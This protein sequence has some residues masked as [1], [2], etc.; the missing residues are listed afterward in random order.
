[1][2]R[3]GAT[4]QEE[5]KTLHVSPI[6]N[7]VA[8]ASGSRSLSSSGGFCAKQHHINQSVWL[9]WHAFVLAQHIAT[10]AVAYLGPP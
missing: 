6:A 1:M 8:A 9:C 3:L 7:F 4:Q 2:L 10:T 5:C